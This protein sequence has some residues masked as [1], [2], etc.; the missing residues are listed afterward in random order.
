MPESEKSK[1]LPDF[2]GNGIAIWINKTDRDGKKLEQPYA[3]IQL[4]GKK[5]ITVYA[6][7][8]REEKK[9]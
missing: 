8:P 6:W 2:S 9:E 3:S 1:R 5:G 7:P 4:F